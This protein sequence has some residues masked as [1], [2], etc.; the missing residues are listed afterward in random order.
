MGPGTTG[1]T[2]SG[3]D[4]WKV[5]RAC[6]GQAEPGNREQGTSRKEQR[7]HTDTFHLQPGCQPKGKRDRDA[8]VIGEA[9]T[10]P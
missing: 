9:G 2:R 6:G 3:K 8:E 4:T 5:S 7:D 10:V 1:R